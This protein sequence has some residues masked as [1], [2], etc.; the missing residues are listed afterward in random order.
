VTVNDDTGTTR[1]TFEKRRYLIDKGEE[2]IAELVRAERHDHVA[3]VRVCEAVYWWPWIEGPT[4]PALVVP[5]PEHLR[6][7][8]EPD[9]WAH[10]EQTVGLLGRCTWEQLPTWQS[11]FG[12]SAL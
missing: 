7:A 1:W 11:G 10:F 5:G 3:W 9:V 6:A 8:D 2:G 4:W 12:E